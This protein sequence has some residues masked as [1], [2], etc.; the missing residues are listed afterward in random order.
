MVPVMRLE[1]SE[2]IWRF[3]SRP[4]VAGGMGP[5]SPIPGRRRA[6]TVEPAAS[7]V[8]PTQLQAGVEVFQPS[9]RSCGVAVRN[10][11][12]ADRSLAVRAAGASTNEALGREEL[13]S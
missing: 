3:G 1:R 13:G 2:R 8:I 4:R 6:T 7:Q 9:F 10:A 11:S 5:R 12:S